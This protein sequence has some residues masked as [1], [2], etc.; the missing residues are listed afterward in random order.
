VQSQQ[1]FASNMMVNDNNSNQQVQRSNNL[2]NSNSVQTNIANINDDV[3]LQRNFSEP[4]NDN[5][6]NAFGN[7]NNMIKQ[8]ASASIPAIQLKTKSLNL[9][10]EMPAIKLPSIKFSSRK[11]L[12]SIVTPTTF[13]ASYNLCTVLEIGEEERNDDRVLIYPNPSSDK[14]NIKMSDRSINEIE[15]YDVNGKKVATSMN[16][17]IDVKDLSNGIYFIRIKTDKGECN[18]NLLRNSCSDSQHSTPDS[19]LLIF[20]HNRSFNSWIFAPLTEE[21]KMYGI[22]S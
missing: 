8:I 3:Q 18:K 4:I 9:N 7:E 10:P 22:L 14:L 6:G 21:K 12:S 1:V 17:S 11:T 5:S 2:N 20:C 15:I 13:A 16:L 19:Q